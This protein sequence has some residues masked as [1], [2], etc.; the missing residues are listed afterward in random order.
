LMIL[1]GEYLNVSSI[2]LQLS[3]Q[4]QRIIC[5]FQAAKINKR[6]SLKSYILKKVT[7][8]KLYFKNYIS[9]VYFKSYISIQK[10]Y[11]NQKSNL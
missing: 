5:V 10:L 8:R 3:I 1:V 9:N 4:F 11:F 2:R 7:F 6:K